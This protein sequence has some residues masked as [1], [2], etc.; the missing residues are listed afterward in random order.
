M[1][2]PPSRSISGRASRAIVKFSRIWRVCENLADL[3]GCA[4]RKSHPTFRRLHLQDLH[5]DTTH[6]LS[7]L[8]FAI[9]LLVYGS[10]PSSLFPCRLL[11][12]FFFLLFFFFSFFFF[13]FF[14]PLV[15]HILVSSFLSRKK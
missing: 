3:A 8:D 9:S 15:F 14:F 12:S 6:R 13:V 11:F 10:L 7:N 4:Y 2:W 1:S 5:P